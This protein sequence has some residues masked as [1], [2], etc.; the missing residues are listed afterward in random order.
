MVLTMQFELALFAS[1]GEVPESQTKKK[2]LGRRED[3]QEIQFAGN[4][5]GKNNKQTIRST[6]K[7]STPLASSKMKTGRVGTAASTRRVNTTTA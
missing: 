1:C 2:E 3:A 5:A 6:K 4:F 7:R